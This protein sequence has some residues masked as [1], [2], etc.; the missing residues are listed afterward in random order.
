VITVDGVDALSLI[1]PHAHL[2]A[3]PGC[4]APLGLLAALEKVAPTRDWTLSSG[5]ILGDYPFLDLVR[6]GSLIYRTWHVMAPVR[7]LVAD[8]TV[9][10]VPVRASRLAGLLEAR[11]VDAAL[12]RV[13]PPDRHGY[14][15]LGPSAGYTL[16]ALRLARIRIGEV[17][18][19]LPWTH[20]R[21]TVPAS[22]FD[23]LVESTEPTP[24]YTSA[25]PDA[26]SR[27]IADHILGLLPREPTL[28]IG[29]GAIPESLVSSLGD[30]GLGRVRFAGMATDEMVDLAEAGVLDIGGAAP[31]IVSPELMG[32]ERLM[33]FSDRNPAVAVHPSSTAHDAVF[34]GGIE[35]FVSINTAIEIDLSGHVNSEVV[36]GRQVSGIGGSLDFV[37]AAT[38]SAGGLRVMALPSTTPDGARSRIVP[39]IGA[40]GTVTIP[41]SM[42]DVVVTEHGVARL[43]GLTTPERAE[44]LIAIA[45]PDHRGPLAERT[46]ADP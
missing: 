2:V 27:V 40:S 6:D 8:G 1:P 45:H 24:A 30:T 12:V 31:A 26:V 9:G 44:A 11:G 16:D 46:G 32:S 37:D 35:R 22:L 42:V 20:G 23:A 3:G 33:A 4:G 5:L 14:C 36:K 15:S 29:I 18:P 41:R 13:T 43:D 34:L 7:S 19:A 10:F 38:R 28:Q 17:D 25:A 39:A 21:T